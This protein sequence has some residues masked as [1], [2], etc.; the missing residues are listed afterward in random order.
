VTAA[1]AGNKRHLLLASRNKICP[2]DGILALQPGPS[3]VDADKS[4]NHFPYNALGL[5]DDFLH[6]CLLGKG[7]AAEPHRFQL[8]RPSFQTRMISRPKK[9]CM[10][11]EYFSVS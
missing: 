6:K 1:S 7:K 10:D 3:G 5:V 8:P 9:A 11:S 2:Q 4:F